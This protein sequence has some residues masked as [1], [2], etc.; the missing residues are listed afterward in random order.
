LVYLDGFY[1]N[2]K[3]K[4]YSKNTLTAI[5]IFNKKFIKI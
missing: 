4:K 3:K 5:K 2:R 1:E